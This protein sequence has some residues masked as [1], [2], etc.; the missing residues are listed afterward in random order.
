VK[1]PIGDIVKVRIDD[2]ENSQN[3]NLY[4][5]KVL[6]CCMPDSYQVNICGLS[7]LR[8]VASS[9]CTLPDVVLLRAGCVP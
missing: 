4:I 8:T 6:F 2:E 3:P 5:D 9:E 7:L 1:E